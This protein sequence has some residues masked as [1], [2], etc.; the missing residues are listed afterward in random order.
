MLFSGGAI[1]PIFCLEIRFVNVLI[2]IDLSGG[3]LL[4][5]FGLFDV[6]IIAI[7]SMSDDF[8]I[9]ILILDLLIDLSFT[10]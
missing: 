9:V 6:A 5:D 3:F 8:Y 4:L 10:L 2:E 7:D 1:E